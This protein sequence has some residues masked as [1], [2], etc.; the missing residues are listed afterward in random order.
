[1]TNDDWED[2]SNADE[3]ATALT[4][5]NKPLVADSKDAALLLTL[6]EGVY[7]F[8]LSGVGGTEGVGLIELFVVE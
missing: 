8:Q 3:L 1:V 6:N 7:T 4:A 5:Q 2:G